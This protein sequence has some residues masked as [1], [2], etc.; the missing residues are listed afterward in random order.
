[1][2]EV[3]KEWLD[4]AYD[5]ILTIGEIIDNPRLTN[6]AAFHAQQAIEKSLKAVIEEFEIGS[7]KTHNLQRLFAVV[8]EFIQFD[9]E[10]ILITKLDVAKQRLKGTG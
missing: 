2:K 3:A 7:I 10:L 1:M 9:V 4:K 8:E 6:I 5:D